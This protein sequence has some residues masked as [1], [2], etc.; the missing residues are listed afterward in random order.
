MTNSESRTATTAPRGQFYVYREGVHGE[1]CI[2][3][4]VWEFSRLATIGRAASRED[5]ENIIKKLGAD[6]WQ[7]PSRS[8][9]SNARTKKTKARK[10]R[11]L[12]KLRRLYSAVTEAVG[13]PAHDA[14][15]QTVA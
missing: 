1:H 3:L 9:E 14:T 4:C 8:P 6:S 10:Q 15:P 2:D 12:E 13:D 7:T 11:Q 5:A